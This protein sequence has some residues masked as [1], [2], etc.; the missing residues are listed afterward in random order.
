[1]NIITV[2]NVLP[3]TVFMLTARWGGWTDLAWRDAFI[4]GGLCTI[5][6][7]AVYV[8]KRATFDRLMLGVNLFLLVGALLFLSNAF[9]LLYYYGAYKGV[10]FLSGIAVVGVITTFFSEAGFIGVEGRNK[11]AIR[12]ASLQLLLFTIFGIIW[13]FVMNNYGLIITAVVPFIMLRIVREK[14]SKQL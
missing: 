9:S 3:L 13:S 11:I 8:Y 1:M 12:K 14:L 7:I 2:I 4:F 5:F 10:V 6:V